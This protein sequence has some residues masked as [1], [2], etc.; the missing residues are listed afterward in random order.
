MFI[1]VTITTLLCPDLSAPSFIPYTSAELSTV[2]P[3]LDLSLLA[4][5]PTVNV[6]PPLPKDDVP[7]V[8]LG[9]DRAAWRADERYPTRSLVTPV[10][11]TVRFVFTQAAQHCFRI[12]LDAIDPRIRAKIDQPF[13]KENL[14]QSFISEAA[15]CHVLLPLWKSGFLAGDACSW[16]LSCRVGP[17]APPLSLSG[18]GPSVGKPEA[19]FGI[20]LHVGTKELKKSLCPPGVDPQMA[21]DLCGMML[22]VVSLPGKLALN[23]EM[24]EAMGACHPQC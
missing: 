6:E 12:D 1:T 9:P 20:D 16:D 19:V 22:D 13:G 17:S 10:E 24:E 7:D 8:E 23:L 14:L 2:V 3:P 21:N 15:L 11:D 5:H 4:E 18:N